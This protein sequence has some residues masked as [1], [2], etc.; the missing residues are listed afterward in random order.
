MSGIYSKS[1]FFPFRRFIYN[2]KLFYLKYH[3]NENWS[4][5]Q[6][7]LHNYLFQADALDNIF[8][9]HFLGTILSI[10]QNVYIL[11]KKYYILLH[12]VITLFSISRVTTKRG[13]FRSKRFI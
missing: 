4:D 2:S 11:R 9:Y 10:V 13:F 5:S 12:L 3:L 7:V 1:D 6:E 8:W